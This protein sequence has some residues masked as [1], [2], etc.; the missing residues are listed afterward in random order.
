M[1]AIYEYSGNIETRAALKLA[2]LL[3]VR[4]GELRK[5]EW[6]HFDFGTAEWRIPPKSMKMRT[7]V[8]AGLRTEATVGALTATSRSGAQRVLVIDPGSEGLER[9]RG[10]RIVDHRWTRMD[11]DLR[12]GSAAHRR[13]KSLGARRY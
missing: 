7:R 3:I 2:P 13:R 8:L 6:A 1:R 12:L 9:A 5:A 10:A 4:P 11:R